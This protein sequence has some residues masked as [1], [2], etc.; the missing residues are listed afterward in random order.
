MSTDT[1]ELIEEE[2]LVEEEVRCDAPLCGASAEFSILLSC[3]H[4]AEL[5]E[6]HKEE[7]VLAT[8]A[9]KWVCGEPPVRIHVVAIIPRRNGGAS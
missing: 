3:G 5:C 7:V 8:D 2:E 9:Q 1:L 6:H 4:H